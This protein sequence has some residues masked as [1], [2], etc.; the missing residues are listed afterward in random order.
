MSSRLPAVAVL[1]ASLA[2][3][4]CGGTPD[5]TKALSVTDVLSGWYDNGVKDGQNHLLPS[6]TFRLK[7]QSDQ[8]IFGV[9]LTVAFWREGEDGEWDSRQV[10]GI[11]GSALPSGQSTG[12]ITV[13][14]SVGHMTEMPRAEIFTSS[15]YKDVVVKMFAKRGGRIF[16]IGEFKVEHRIIPQSVKDAGRR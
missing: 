12:S 15:L 2:A 7:N 14:A 9:Q 5:L 8:S 16:S 10:S 3:A 4:T 1:A 13:R 6:I 11:G